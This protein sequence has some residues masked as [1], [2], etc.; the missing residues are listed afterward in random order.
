MQ[1]DTISRVIINMDNIDDA[2]RLKQR[3]EYFC[4]FALRGGAVEMYVKAD[5][6]LKRCG[7]VGNDF[8][9]VSVEHEILNS[10]GN[11]EKD[12]TL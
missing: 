8:E 5:N 3:L 4:R 10:D 9:A 6:H 2:R 7:L 1:N 11:F 12:T